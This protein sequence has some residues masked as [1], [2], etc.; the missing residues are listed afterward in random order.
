[1]EYNWII[2]KFGVLAYANIM[3][4]GVRSDEKNLIQ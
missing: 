1:M 4:L 2:T 3:L